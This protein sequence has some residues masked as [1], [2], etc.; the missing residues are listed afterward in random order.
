M[1]KKDDIRLVDA[2]VRK[3]RLSEVQREILHDWLAREK[4]QDVTYQEILDLGKDVKACYP[5][6]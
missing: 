1:T 5:R 2:V 4:L 6:K 3:L